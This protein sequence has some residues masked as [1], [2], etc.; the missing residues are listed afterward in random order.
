MKSKFVFKYDKN[1]KKG[2]VITDKGEFQ[3]NL[4]KKTAEPVS[5]NN[6]LSGSAGSDGAGYGLHLI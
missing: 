4:R 5:A 2:I 3:I 1:T 6:E